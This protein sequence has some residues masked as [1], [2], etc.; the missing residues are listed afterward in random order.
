MTAN[1]RAANFSHRS[2]GG[3]PIAFAPW[4]GGAVS[5]RRSES[6]SHLQNQAFFAR[7]RSGELANTRGAG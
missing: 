7:R 5:Y 2:M 1:R 3:F 4:P 6:R